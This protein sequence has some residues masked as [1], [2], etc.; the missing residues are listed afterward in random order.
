MLINFCFIFTCLFA[1]CSHTV[2]YHGSHL[3]FD[4]VKPS[5][6]QRIDGEVVRWQGTAIFATHDERVALFYTHN[7]I[8]GYS[9]GID[10]INPIRKEDPIEFTLIG[11]SSLEEALEKLYGPLEGAGSEGFIYT[12]D[13][14]YFV[15]EDGLGSLEAV[16]YDPKA[17]LSKKTISRRKEI[18]HFVDQGLVHLRWTASLS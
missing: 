4:Q 17:T 14:A 7:V 12:M 16:A 1:D 11:G 2:L 10:L 3:S 5:Y 15:K 18:Q 9:A 13:G 8:D 6:S